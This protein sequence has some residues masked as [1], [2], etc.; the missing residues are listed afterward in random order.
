MYALFLDET[1]LRRILKE[2]VLAWC[3]RASLLHSLDRRQLQRRKSHRTPEVRCSLEIR[4]CH[5]V[6]SAL[7]LLQISV[8][9]MNILILWTHFVCRILRIPAFTVNPNENNHYI[10]RRL[11][12]MMMTTA[13]ESN[14]RYLRLGPSDGPVESQAL[15]QTL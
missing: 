1:S 8:G 15:D 14:Q 2:Y 10:N 12:A 3:K 7:L 13:I 9:D 5:V 6:Q 11:P 4:V